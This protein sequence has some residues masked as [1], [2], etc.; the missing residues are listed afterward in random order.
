MSTPDD[1]IE[2]AKTG[3]DWAFE[4]EKLTPEDVTKYDDKG[5]TFLHYVAK[6]GKWDK[7]PKHLQDKKYWREGKDGETIYMSAFR[8]LSVGWIM[9]GVLDEAEIIKK[10]NEGESIITI[11]AQTTQFNKLFE[12]LFAHNVTKTVLTQKY[13]DNSPEDHDEC[14]IH[15]IASENDLKYIPQ[16]VLTEDLLSLKG[17]DGNT[18]YHI[19]A[20]GCQIH[21]LPKE[22]LTQNALTIENNAGASVL[23]RLAEN[24]AELIPE[25]LLTQELFCK[26]CKDKE[27]PLQAWARSGKWD[28]IPDHLLTRE[29]LSIGNTPQ[30]SPIHH[31]LRKYDSQL[32]NGEL[33]QGNPLSKKVS[34]IINLVNI[35]TLEALKNAEERSLNR[36]G[37]DLNSP[38][39]Y[40]Q[41][42]KKELSKRKIVKKLSESEQSLSI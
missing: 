35:E 29:T 19:L 12:K 23:Y 32:F 4:W 22:T 6:N 38:T 14:T 11:A 40:M 18:V 26:V 8:G 3:W 21:L 2:H 15:L 25:K 33:L 27:S 42:I 28:L 34:R 41:S 36:L 20:Q 30:E 13:M 24:Q 31:I 5:L 17:R 39:W 37:F 1:P 10:N 9:E 16:S 7:L